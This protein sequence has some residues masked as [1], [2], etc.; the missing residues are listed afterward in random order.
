LATVAIVTGTYLLLNVAYLVLL[1]LQTLAGTDSAASACAEV[2][3]GSMGARVV[4]ALVTFSAFG[5]LFGIAMAAPRYAWA[6]AQDGLFFRSV[7]QVDPQTSAPRVGATGLLVATL[8]YLASGS[9][10]DILGFFVAIHGIYVVLSLAAIYPL[11]R[12]DAGVA[13]FRVPGYPFVPALAI[14]AMLG[15]TFSEVLRAP[16]RTGTGIGVLMLAAPAYAL[17]RR[18]A[19]A[20]GET[21]R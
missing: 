10:F 14:V 3:L 2:V 16:L 9:F 1:P 7:A 5:T 18:F 6:I 21:V 11:R 4:A 8:A 15:V 12:R 13:S 20:G 19:V 17:W